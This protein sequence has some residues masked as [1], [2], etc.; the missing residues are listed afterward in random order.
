MFVTAAFAC[1]GT[2]VA[3]VAGGETKDPMIAMPRAV[4]TLMFRIVFFY[5]VTLLFLT[6]VVSARNP[7]LLGSKSGSAVEASPFVIAI[8]EAGI[9]VLPD[10]LN[11]IVLLCVS[12][13]GSVSIYTGSRVLYNM[14]DIGLISSRWGFGKVDER[15]RPYDTPLPSPPSMIIISRYIT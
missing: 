2:E 6:F 7:A 13:V 15:G 11:V 4:R 3:G 14:T 12:S 5:V 1:G 9:G 8:K 10:V